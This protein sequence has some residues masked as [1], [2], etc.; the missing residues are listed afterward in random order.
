MLD[1]DGCA[2]ALNNGYE[3]Y[4]KN[5]SMD[6]LDFLNKTLD[7]YCQLADRS[8]ENIVILTSAGSMNIERKKNTEMTLEIATKFNSYWA[9]CIAPLGVPVTLPMGGVITSVTNDAMSYVSSLKSDLDNLVTSVPPGDNY[10]QF[11]KLLFDYAKKIVWTVVE[12]YPNPST[13]VPV[14]MT[15][16]VNVS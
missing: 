6:Y 8:M 16:S 12:T 7:T 3:D 14:V 11:C 9:L 1:S 10:K 5:Q 13:G 2:N 4:K 15:Y